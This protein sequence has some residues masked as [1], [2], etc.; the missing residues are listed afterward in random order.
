[1][2]KENRKKIRR[3][4]H[5]TAW[6]GLDG[7]PRRGCTVADI[8]ETGARLQIDTPLELPEIFKLLLSGHGAIYR[9][10]RVVW[11]SDNEVGVEFE[12][13]PSRFARGAPPTKTPERAPA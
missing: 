2:F 4:M 12:K 9:R 13:T 7:A 1:M 10:C 5:Y 6:I 8:S 11:R 3:P